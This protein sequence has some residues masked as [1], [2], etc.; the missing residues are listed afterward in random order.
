[1]LLQQPGGQRFPVAFG[2]CVTFCTLIQS[3]TIKQSTSQS[4]NTSSNFFSNSCKLKF[5][6]II[7]IS[8]YRYIPERRRQDEI[9]QQISLLWGSTHRLWKSTHRSRLQRL[10]AWSGVSAGAWASV[11]ELWRFVLRA[12]CSSVGWVLPSVQI[13]CSVKWRPGCWR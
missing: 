4:E 10:A 12:A 5:R 7:M 13:F 6:P 11:P 1:M 9:W 2:T 3:S 8:V